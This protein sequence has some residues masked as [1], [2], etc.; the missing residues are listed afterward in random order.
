MAIPVLLDCDPGH[1]D[2]LAIMLAA[3]SPAIDLLGRPPNARVAVDLHAD[4]F[5]DLIVTAIAV[6]G[7]GVSGAARAAPSG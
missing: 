1:D 7:R 2:A 4:R 6:L 3:G 5:W